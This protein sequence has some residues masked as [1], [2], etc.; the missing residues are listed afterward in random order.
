MSTKVVITITSDV[1]SRNGRTVTF[2][3]G[4]PYLMKDINQSI[5]ERPGRNS[6][7][8]LERIRGIVISNVEASKQRVDNSSLLNKKTVVE[9]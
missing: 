1:I 4:D 9:I 5:A 8:V 3:Y 2:T 6:S 7:D